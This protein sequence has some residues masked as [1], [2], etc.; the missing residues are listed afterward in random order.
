MTPL[1]RSSA[2]VEGAR[3]IRDASVFPF[4]KLPTELRHIV[5]R[6]LLV[7]PA[8]RNRY[9]SA[10]GWITY[11]LLHGS[12][13]FTNREIYKEATRIFFSGTEF[14]IFKIRAYTISPRTNNIPI[15]LNLK[16]ERSTKPAFEVT[17]KRLGEDENHDAEWRTLITTPEGIISIIECL[18]RQDIANTDFGRNLALGLDFYNNF[19]SRHSNLIKQVVLP[20]GQVQR[21]KTFRFSGRIGK[22]TFKHLKEYMVNGSPLNT[23]TSTMEGFVAKGDRYYKQEQYHLAKAH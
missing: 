5:Y 23:I 21:F 15:L 13:I 7:Q 12:I 9:Y 10:K 2:M 17:I 4:L 11:F 19:P 1:I 3:G 22:D 16:E 20:W 6:L 14:V 8:I 18:W